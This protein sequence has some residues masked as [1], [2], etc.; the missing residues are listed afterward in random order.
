MTQLSSGD[1][2]N[3]QFS[4]SNQIWK[5]QNQNFEREFEICDRKET[6]IAD[7]KGQRY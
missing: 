7:Q 6:K 5:G 4:I 1:F 3:F 2:G